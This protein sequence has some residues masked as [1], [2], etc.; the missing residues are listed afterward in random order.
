MI[1]SDGLEGNVYALKIKERLTAELKTKDLPF[2]I[3]ADE[4]TDPH[5][6]Q[7]ILSLCLRFVDQS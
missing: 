4:G 3:I 6:N 2:M 5:S 7:E 1:K